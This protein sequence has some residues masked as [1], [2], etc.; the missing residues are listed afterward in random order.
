MAG[1]VSA[2]KDRRI[3][4]F[5]RKKST[6]ASVTFTF[7]RG[8]LRGMRHAIR[9]NARGDGGVKTLTPPIAGKGRKRGVAVL[10]RG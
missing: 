10:C 9:A 6:A 7:L 1:G 3:L 8:D 2:E 5:A 4:A